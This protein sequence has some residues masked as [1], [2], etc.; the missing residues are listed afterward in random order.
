MLIVCRIHSSIGSDL[1]FRGPSILE[2]FKLAFSK[3]RDSISTHLA[4]ESVTPICAAL[5]KLCKKSLK[6]SLC[7]FLTLVYDSSHFPSS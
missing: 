7:P 5:D 2:H 1:N 4:S 3:L 6:G